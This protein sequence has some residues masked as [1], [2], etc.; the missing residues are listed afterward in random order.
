MFGIYALRQL[1]KTQS[2]ITE[3]QTLNNSFKNK[4]LN[5]LMPFRSINK[6]PKPRT[7]KIK[8]L[9]SE[10]YVNAKAYKYLCPGP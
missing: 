2:I 9:A 5:Q 7:L 8:I 4:W 10:V 6:L 1:K 3:R